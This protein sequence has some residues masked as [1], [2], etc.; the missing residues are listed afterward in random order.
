M[1]EKIVSPGVFTKEIDKSFLPAAIGDIGAAVVGPTVKGPTLRPTV[2]ESFGDYQ[3]R[4]G[5]VFLSSSA[6]TG[7]GSYYRHLTSHL[8]E[9]YLRYG[10]QLTVVRTLAGSYSHA[11]ATISASTDPNI[12]GGGTPHSASLTLVSNL[13][14]ATDGTAVDASASF[15]HGPN[16]ATETKF[17]FTSSAALGALN[18]AGTSFNTST[19]I[20][21]NSGSSLGD[22]ADLLRDTINNSS[23]LHGLQISA[24]SDSANNTVGITSS[25]A[26]TRGRDLDGSNLGQ[27]PSHG[28]NGPGLSGSVYNI[29]H[30]AT[31]I[32]S[33]Q[34]MGGKDFNS[35]S[36][37]SGIGSPKI[38]FK[39]HTL[40]EGTEQNSVGPIGT[41][42]S[43]DSGSSSNLRWEISQRN[44]KKGTF[45]LVIRSGDDIDNRT[46]P[47]ETWNNL[48]LDPNSPNFISKKI[49]DTVTVLKN[50]GTND[51]YLQPSGSYL[52]ASKYVRVEVVNT[53]PDYLDEN[54]NVR[55]PAASASLPHCSGSGWSGSFGGS[56]SGGSDGDI[57]HP[58]GEGAYENITATTN[59]QG[60]N[61]GSGQTGETSYYDS[62]ELLR[63]QDE[64]DFNLLFLPG[65]FSDT[66]TSIVSKAIDVC[67]DRGD[68]FVV[69]DP[70]P[71]KSAPTT[72]KSAANA[73]NSNYAAMYYPWVQIPDNLTG[74]PRWVPPSIAVSSVYA[75]NDK[76]K[77]PWFA[78][79]GL[80]RGTLDN[81][82]QAERVVPIADRDDLYEGNVNPIARFSGQG[83]VV[84]GQKTL[85]KKS[86]ALDRVNVRRL[87]IKVKK[88]IASSS[89]F[90]VFEQ[91]NNATRQRFLSIVNPFLEQIQS[92]SG[93]NAFRVV[94]DDTNN[95]PDVV[96]RN[97]LYGQIFVQ[98]TKTAE[99]IILDF[100]VQPTGA[101]FPS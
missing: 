41:R 48:T 7:E 32:T 35:G 42:C 84:W 34:F 90:L 73:R 51:V 82:I 14:M 2:V 5:D 53:T 33:N 40:S 24:S 23:S 26:G 94:M 52:N 66:H 49:G 3:E 8:A 29:T 76:V 85:Q 38:S 65:I 81:I 21:V 91:N 68:C 18:A 62:L 83:N 69:L 6:T 17:V 50:S 27:E 11:S 13:S 56:F 36:L 71:F 47:L 97:I 60:L 37:E 78:P 87:L 99:F 57:V 9:N 54:G 12:V 20:Y 58:F 98:P 46:K 95:T 59:T 86:S 10:S 39:L 4:F 31:S 64:Y 44:N 100:T 25:F 61:L 22:S 75:F 1:A 70:S 16:N 67:E 30:T 19:L 45:T 63:N 77:H 43:L 88:F 74:T 28:S 89:R 101:S 93:L 96:D 72:A 15:W 79:A 92:N 80:N 55:I